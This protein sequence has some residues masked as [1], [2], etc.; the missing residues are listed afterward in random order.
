MTAPLACH[1]ERPAG[2]WQFATKSPFAPLCERGVGG[3]SVAALPRNDAGGRTSKITAPAP[4]REIHYVMGTLLEIT[5]YHEPQE[6]GKRVL[7]RCFQEAQ[8]LEDIFSAYDDGS[9]LS[10]LNRHAGLGP[11][12][13]NQELW[14]ALESALHLGRETEETMDITVGPLIDLWKAAEERGTIPS[15]ASVTKALDRIGI[16]KVQLL[17]GGRAE[18]RQAGMRLNLGGIGKG[19]AVDHLKAILLHERVAS[20]FINFGRSSLAA[21]GSPPERESW[22]VLLGSDDGTPIGLAHL[23]DQ[24]LSV[25]SSFGH[26]FEIEG[27][28]LGHLID[29]RNGFPVRNLILGVAV[30]RTATEAEAL[31]KALVILGPTRGFAVVTRFSKA[32]GL[33]TYSNGSQVSTSGFIETVRFET[34]AAILREGI[35]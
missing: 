31:T 23:K 32:E 28:R 22:P 33:L 12:E 30:A 7:A 15:P 17:P 13:I 1:C 16:S 3:I 24:H 9:D 4:L 20:A 35:S 26:S 8:R 14:S 2:A 27:T 21:V 6:E 5:L 18:L 19:Y 25:S 34:T 10:R 11:V 29:P